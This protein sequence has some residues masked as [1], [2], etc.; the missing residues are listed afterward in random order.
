MNKGTTPK[1]FRIPNDIIA[2]I[3]KVAKEN[4]TTFSKEGLSRLSNKGKENKKIPVILAKTQ[5]IINLCM[6]GVKKG[7]IEPIQKAQEV[8]KKLWAKTMISS[9]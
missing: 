6:E 2:D 8:E 1:T 3:E 7:T 4:N 5:T 9:K